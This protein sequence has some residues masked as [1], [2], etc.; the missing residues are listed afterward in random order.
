MKRLSKL[1]LAL[2]IACSI[3]GCS[4]STE[5]VDATYEIYIAG[6]D[7]GCGVNKTILTLDKA[8]DDVDKNDFMVSETKQVTDW[9]DEALPVVEKTLERVVDDAYSCDKDGQKIDGES[10]Y[11]A[12]E[13]YV[14]PN[15]GSPLLYSATTHYNTWSDPY[16]L[17]ISLAKNGEI[18]VD[19]KKVTK[20]DVST[21]YTKKITAADALE[22][23]KFKAS[24]GIELNYGHFNPKEP[25]NTL[26]VW[27]HGSGEGG[28]EDT[29]PQ[30]TSLSNKVS[31]YFNDDFQNAVGNAYVLVPQCP[32]FWMD[33]DG[34]GGE[35]NDDLLVTHGPS[36]Y[37]NA[38]MELIKDYQS[39]CGAT[40]VVLA[41]CSAGGSGSG[42]E[43]TLTVGLFTEM[44]GD[45][46]PMYYQTVNDHNVVNLVYQG[47]L[48]YDKD[49]NLVPELAEELPTISDDGTTMT[50]KLKKGVKFSDGSKLTSKDVKETFSVMADP[51]Y[52]GLYSSNV[53]FVK[54][55]TEYHDG[56]LKI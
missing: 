33:A 4:Q 7:W 48:A 43:Q 20:L 19:D 13:L 36:Y 52:T 10:K 27:L 8:V 46:S 5:V 56:M 50:F 34:N 30:V 14:S 40:K 35:W 28:T 31:A 6:Y 21:E 11:I 9:E 38:L 44:N 49:A 26:F 22:L 39:R 54:G 47:L 24:D 23:E 55:Y 2:F 41:G 32:T 42:K 1:L 25:S 18:T 3:T 16:Y 51:S 15:D 17:N 12:I 29:N 45:F 37:T 53:D